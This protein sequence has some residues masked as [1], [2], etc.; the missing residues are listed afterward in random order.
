MGDGVHMALG[1]L[2][3]APNPATRTYYDTRE[4]ADLLRCSRK[5]VR[6]YVRRGWLTPTRIGRRL[7]VSADQVRALLEQGQRQPK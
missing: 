6:R 7:L 2:Y 3:A 5:T 4:L 1:D